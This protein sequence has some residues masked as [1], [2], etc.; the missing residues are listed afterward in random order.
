MADFPF[1]IVGFDLDGTLF[2]T[3]GDIAAALNRVLADKRRAPLTVAQVVPMIG[4]G[5]RAT[6]ERG[7]A[8]T[9]GSDPATVEADHAAMLAHYAAHIADHTRPYPGAVAALDALRARGVKV[10][11]VTNKL[12]RLATAIVDALGLADRFATVIGGDTLGPGKAKPSPALLEEMVRRCGGGRAA[13]V[14]DSAFDVQAARAAG[15]PVVAVEWGFSNE[16]VGGLG[17]DAVIARFDALVAVLE[18]I[19]ARL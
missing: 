7:L 6:L 17:A 14:G 11:I 15:M 9:G 8:A 4:G 1:D 19:G 3:S 13:F 16:P 12:E 18:G 5:L 10:A 2:D